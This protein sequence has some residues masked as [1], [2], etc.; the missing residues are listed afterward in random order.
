MEKPTFSLQMV[1]EMYELWAESI[2]RSQKSG[3]HNSESFK[4]TAVVCILNYFYYNLGSKRQAPLLGLKKL[5][6]SF[7]PSVLSW[8]EAKI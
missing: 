8:R 5:R 3:K 4:F 6:A 2:W 7:G 1:P